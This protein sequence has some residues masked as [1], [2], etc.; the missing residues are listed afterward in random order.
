MPSIYG[1]DSV[2]RLLD[3]QFAMKHLEDLGYEGNDAER[4]RHLLSR[5]NGIF[6]ITGPTGSGKS[7]TLYTVI[8]QIHNETIN[9]ITVE[10]PVE[11]SLIH[12]SEPTRPY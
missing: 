9:I 8:E 12:I 3:S 1:E 5:N 11:L 4:I 10:D 2:I 7:T 6:L